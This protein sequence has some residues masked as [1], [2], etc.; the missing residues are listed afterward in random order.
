MKL[1]FQVLIVSLILS[2]SIPWSGAQTTSQPGTYDLD[3]DDDHITVSITATMSQNITTIPAFSFT[4]QGENSSLAATAVTNSIR[5]KT[6][7][8]TLSDFT[9]VASSNSSLVSLSVSFKVLGPVSSDQWGNAQADIAWRSFRVEDDLVIN[10]T[11]FNLVGKHYFSTPLL[12]AVDQAFSSTPLLRTQ[13]EIDGKRAIPQEVEQ[14]APNLNL[15]DFT[16]LSTSLD[17]WSR[18]F[19]LAPTMTTWTRQAGFD[20]AIVTIQSEP[21]GGQ[22]T[23]KD[24]AFYKVDTVIEVPGI[25]NNVGETIFF[26]ET[27]FEALMGGITVLILIIAVAAYFAERRITSKQRFRPR[28]K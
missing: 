15:L 12:L 10:G 2:L 8:V 25:A 23:I 4:I 18:Q 26:G 27:M 1:P 21:L 11:A 5:Q 9:L 3:I 28:K 19:T 20:V 17:S 14:L 24:R 16:R 7:N 13:F 6:P 22:F